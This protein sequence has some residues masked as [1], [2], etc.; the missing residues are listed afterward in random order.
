MIVTMNHL[1]PDQ[2]ASQNQSDL[3]SLG[4]HGALVNFQHTPARQQKIA[5]DNRRLRSTGYRPANWWQRRLL[6]ALT[7]LA[8]GQLR[9][10]FP[11]GE[12][13]LLIGTS[14]HQQDSHQSADSLSAQLQFHNWRPI[15]RL[16]LEGA[17]GFLE[18]YGDG[19][20]SSPD[21]TA[22]LRLASENRQAWSQ[23][24]Q[25]KWWV[26][27][28][29]RLHHGLRRN[30]RSGS[31]RNI[32]AHYDLGNDFYRLWLDDTMTYS[33]ALFEQPDQ[34]LAEAQRAKYRALARALQLQPG[35]QVLE[36]G[37]GWGGFAELAAQEFGVTVT[38]LTISQ[39]QYQAVVQRV[40]E[41]G[42]QDRI[43][44]RLCDY[45]DVVGQYDA[46]A[47]IEMFEAVGEAFWPVYFSKL[48]QLL[49]PS[50]RAGLQVITIDHADFPRYR[51]RVDFIQ[52]HIFPGGMLPSL[53]IL[54]NLTAAV[55]MQP[56]ASHS[57]GQDYARTLQH[58]RQDFL[59]NRTAISAAGYDE[60]FLKLWEIYFCYCEA[61]FQT[62]QLDVHHLVYQQT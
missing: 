59:A 18:S 41:A 58:W 61:G 25:G 35:Q 62:G 14:S 51:N 19:D 16:M 30:S 38:A 5:N 60:R 50:G 45:R 17:V 10:I 4:D 20:W 13:A 24:L 8:A 57:F 40:A 21:I 48:H 32:A 27:Q 53:T 6:A 55:G 39:A 46:I 47:S 3:A 11:H 34:S 43:I 12:S 56:V 1:P 52:K 23:A 42:L 26:R 22:L 36:V 37:C 49:K 9:L 44:V 7:P 54:D 29:N 31:R 33:A 15:R 28:I 2:L